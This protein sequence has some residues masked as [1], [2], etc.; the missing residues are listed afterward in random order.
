MR[1][2]K[3]QWKRVLAKMSGAEGNKSG[4]TPPSKSKYVPLVQLFLS[5]KNSMSLTF[6]IEIMRRLNGRH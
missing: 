5:A 2:I 1:G 3:R 4:V 6:C